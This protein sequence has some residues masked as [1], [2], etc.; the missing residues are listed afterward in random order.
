[1]KS[2]R[3]V[4]MYAVTAMM[5]GLILQ[6]C[7]GKNNSG[8]PPPQ[9]PITGVPPGGGCLPGQANCLVPG[10]GVALLNGPAIASLDYNGSSMILNFA[11]TNVTTGQPYTGQVNIAGTI[12]L[13][14]GCGMLPPGDYP[15]QG[16]GNWVSNYAGAVAG[17][18]GSLSM[19]TG[20][21]VQLGSILVHYGQDQFNPGPV[22]FYFQG[23][24]YIAA[25]GGTFTA[26]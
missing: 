7:P 4:V 15:V 5:V 14:R 2:K 17:V 21:A 10:G 22:G 6:G 12:R 1:M 19:S 18:N 23:P 25:C 20:Q 8:A 16:Q 13:A 9:G 3:N 26:L 24:V 11:A